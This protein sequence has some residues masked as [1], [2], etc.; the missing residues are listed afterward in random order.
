MTC[1]RTPTH[2]RSTTAH[3]AS[4]ARLRGHRSVRLERWL[5][6]LALALKERY[7]PEPVTSV[8]PQANGKLQTAGNSDN[9]GSCVHDGCDAGSRTDLRSRLAPEQYAYRQ[10]RNAQQAAVRSSTLIRGIGRWS[11]R[12]C[13]ATSTVSRTPNLLKIG[14]ASHQRSARLAA[15]QDVAG[16][17]VEETDERGRKTRTTRNKDMDA[18]PRRAPHLSAVG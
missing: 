10:G 11:T 17:P 1:W 13:P 4:M 18:E 9:P 7:C 3:R 8:H 2:C 6:E 12:I 5:G 14:G 16:A 15:D